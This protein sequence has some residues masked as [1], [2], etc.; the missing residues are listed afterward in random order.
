VGEARSEQQA[1]QELA[2]DGT[3]PPVTPTPAE[4]ANVLHEEQTPSVEPPV[5]GEIPHEDMVPPTPAPPRG[6]PGDAQRAT[7]PEPP[8]TRPEETP[9]VQEGKAGQAKTEEDK[10]LVEKAKGYLRGED[11]D[12]DHLR[13]E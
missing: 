12:R 3:N 7:S 10:G 9:R 13:G 8:P 5:P 11:R 4:A 1:V 6:T 2:P